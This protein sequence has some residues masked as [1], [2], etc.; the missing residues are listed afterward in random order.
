MKDHFT[1]KCYKAGNLYWIDLF[2]GAGGTSSGIH[3]AGSHV[4]GCVNHD[5]NAIAAHFANHPNTIHFEE[6]IRDFRVVEKLKELVDFVRRTDPH[7]I[8]AIWA[9]LECTNFSKAKGGQARDPDSR[10][11][12][13]HMFM[14]LKELNPE[15]FWVENVREFLDWG[16]MKK[17]RERRQEKGYIAYSTCVKEK[18]TGK[19]KAATVEI[20]PLW[21]PIKERKAQ[22]Y[23][24]WILEVQ[25]H[26]Y[27]YEYQ[28]LNAAD[29]GSYQS[30]ERLFIQF[31]REKFPMTW[32]PQTHIKATK[33][34]GTSLKKHMPVKEILDLHDEGESIFS[35]KKSYSE[36][37]LKRIY[38]GLVKFVANGEDMFRVQYNGGKK[39]PH[40]RAISLDK[41]CSMILNN[42]TH[43]IVKTAFIQKYF[44]G[45]PAGK[46][47]S[48]DGPA[49]TVPTVGVQALVQ[50]IH[51]STYNGNAVLRSIEEPAPVVPTKD[52]IAKIHVSFIDQQYG[53]STPASVE[54]S[55]GTL[56]IN[57]K[58]AL[59]NVET[60]QFIMNQ[61]SNGGQLTDLEGVSS[62]VLNVPKQ[63][64]VTAEKVDENHHFILNPSWYGHATDINEPCVAIVARQDKAPLS[65]VSV[66][67]GDVICFVYEDDCETMLKIKH[68][69]VAYGITDI[70][71]RM[72]NIPELK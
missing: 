24:K 65:V 55:I 48:V 36:N 42:G 16:P 64:L 72:L 6:D 2:C 17:K 52:R 71:M 59:V 53:K 43:A 35:R 27:E 46:V 25:D 22:F 61:F 57:P 58:F 62:C 68:F 39:N 13:N 45:R 31:K 18:W 8:I 9:S 37:T 28:L 50:A 12:A 44:S 4:L 54:N 49:G 20:I 66:S 15:Y 30:R 38:A 34:T 19:G 23:N 67:T 21:I 69:M 10:T 33:V 29:F 60:H 32:P 40:H 63:N 41:P 3:L 1:L 26:G 51:L 11:L 56:T 47:I 70:K 14:Y 7:A 5:K